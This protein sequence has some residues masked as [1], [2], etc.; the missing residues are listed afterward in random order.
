MEI[1]IGIE[2]L[3]DGKKKSRYDSEWTNV[4]SEFFADRV[5]SFD[6]TAAEIAGRLSAQR[7]RRG[8]NIDTSDTQI[9]AIV[10]AHNAAIATRNVRHFSDLPI[11]VID[12]WTT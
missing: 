6:R 7:A 11:S 4:S 9:A 10:V 3:P 1:R 2:L 12:P 8:L 5:L